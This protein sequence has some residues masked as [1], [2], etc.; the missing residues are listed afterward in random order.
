[1]RE[2]KDKS[3]S[4]NLIDQV[5]KESVGSS[6]T[7]LELNLLDE[8]KLKDAEY[9]KLEKSCKKFR[10]K[11]LK[12]YE[13][14]FKDILEKDDVMKKSDI[15]ID[16]E[17]NPNIKPTNARTPVEIPLHLRSAANGE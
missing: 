5:I 17:K 3:N 8:D 9:L 4:P 2:K 1:M 15:K 12:E 16:V 7:R 13:D 14:I 10:S 11:L 6:R